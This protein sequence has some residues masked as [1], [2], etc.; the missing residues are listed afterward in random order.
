L[1]EPRTVAAE[2]ARRAL[3]RRGQQKIES[4]NMP[5]VLENRATNRLVG[6]LLEA[7]SGRS[8]QQRRSFLL[9]KK[10]ERIG[11]KS[12]T[13]IDDP[14]LVG[15]LASQ[16]FDSDGISARR[17]TLID[18]GL[19][20]EYLVD[21][22]Y[23]R[24]LGVD[25]TGGATSNLILQRGERDPQALIGTID[26]GIYVTSILGGNADPTTGDFSHGVS[27]FEIV[28]G[29]LGRPVGE[30]NVTGS[31]VDLWNK[32]SEVGNDPNPYSRWRLPTMVFDDL[33]VSGT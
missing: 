19:L 27:G 24:K 17:R 12:L 1:P 31:H 23:A 6:H 14:L 20:K 25:P 11:G 4:G 32:L 28:N 2:A 26:R 16:H 15:G 5:V 3:A 29:T 33:S 9:G 30:M 13:L 10:G 22:Y 8:I 7:M 18:G 21:V